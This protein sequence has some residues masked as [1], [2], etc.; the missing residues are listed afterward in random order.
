MNENK[1]VVVLGDVNIDFL[2][3]SNSDNNSY[4]LK[5]LAQL[6]FENIFPHGVVQC[7]SEPTQFWPGR[8]PSGLDH[9]YTNYPEILSQP[10]VMHYGG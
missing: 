5:N 7:I 10:L 4:K 9:I 6:V 1:E 8:E 3:W 2:K